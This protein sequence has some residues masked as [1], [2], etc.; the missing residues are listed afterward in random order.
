MKDTADAKMGMICL[1]STTVM[2]HGCF[3]CSVHHLHQVQRD[4]VHGPRQGDHV[5]KVMLGEQR[6]GKGEWTQDCSNLT[7]LVTHPQ[8]SQP[9]L[10][11]QFRTALNEEK[12]GG[13]AGC[14]Q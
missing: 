7:I 12:N 6:V 4:P 1:V 9:Q 11:F 10:G 5:G 14:C 2:V 13:G 3:I 8:M